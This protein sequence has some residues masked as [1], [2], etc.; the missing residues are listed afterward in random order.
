M[1]TCKELDVNKRKNIKIKVGTTDIKNPKSFYIIIKTWCEPTDNSYYDYNRVIRNLNK[2]IKQSLY[3]YMLIKDN[4]LFDKQRTIVDLDV[5]DSGVRLGKKSFMNCEINLFLKNKMESIKINDINNI[6][7]EYI[8]LI[9]DD[10]FDN[11]RY[12]NFYKSKKD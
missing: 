12:F 6:L 11:Y 9:M 3:D 4:C 1:K 5:R 7:D 2:Q 10:V 8:N